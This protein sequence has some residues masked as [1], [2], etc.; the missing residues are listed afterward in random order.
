MAGGYLNVPDDSERNI[1]KRSVDSKGRAGPTLQRIADQYI[2]HKNNTGM[3]QFLFEAVAP[4]G[5][6]SGD[7]EG[8]YIPSKAMQN[9]KGLAKIFQDWYKT[10]TPVINIPYMKWPEIIESG[11]FK[12]Q[13]ELAGKNKPNAWQDRIKIE[14]FFGDF[15]Y[16]QS[17]KGKTEIMDN[18]FKTLSENM[19]KYTPDISNK[20]KLDYIKNLIEARKGDRKTLE[21]SESLAKKSPVYGHIYNPKYNDPSDAMWFGNTFAEMS[22]KVKDNSK[23]VLG[24]SG[25][26]KAL[27]SKAFSSDDMLGKTSRLERALFQK[28]MNDDDLYSLRKNPKSYV[29]FMEMWIPN[30]LA[31]LNNVRS[32]HIPKKSSGEEFDQAISPKELPKTFDFELRKNI[33]PPDDFFLPKLD[34]ETF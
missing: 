23:Y 1:Q 7:A 13:M 8:A 16:P 3:L 11:K 34:W 31:R 22:D 26:G 15:P 30:N 32:V 2:T 20:E 10:G 25:A 4:M 29:D 5:M 17:I 19:R 12:N 33:H 24:D 9:A 21:Y 27:I 6:Y 18:Y 14:K 28:K